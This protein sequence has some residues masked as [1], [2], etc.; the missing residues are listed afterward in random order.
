[1]YG[2]GKDIKV[3]DFKG[4]SAVELAKQINDWLAHRAN[5]YDIH[6]MEYG[7]KERKHYAIVVYS[8]S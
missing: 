3:K 8:R 5:D 1:M 2:K 4:D 6:D 7:V